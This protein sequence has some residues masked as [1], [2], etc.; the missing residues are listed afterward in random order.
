MCNLLQGEQKVIETQLRICKKEI[1]DE[2]A[3][4]KR[5]QSRCFSSRTV[6]PTKEVEY[7]DICSTSFS[8]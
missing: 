4:M 1:E 5:K 2:E 6:A 7:R 8:G 3:K